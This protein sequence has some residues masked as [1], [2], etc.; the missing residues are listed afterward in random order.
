MT[1]LAEEPFP[2]YRK[3][4]PPLAGDA[5]QDELTRLGGAWQLV[6]G[7]HL[8]CEYRFED[9]AAALDAAFTGWWDL[10]CC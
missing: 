7:H 1:L 6:A 5:L 9:F 10:L 2:R 8:E 3:G 4:D